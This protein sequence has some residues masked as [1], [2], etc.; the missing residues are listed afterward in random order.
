MTKVQALKKLMEDNEGLASWSLIYNELEKYYPNIKKSKEW[1][2]GIRGVLYR[3]IGKTFKKLDNGLFAILEFKENK[4]L[5]NAKT[6]E[7]TMEIKIRIGQNFFRKVL[8]KN[9]IFCPFTNIKFTDLLIASHIKPWNKSDD[10]ERLDVYNGFIF[11]PTYDKLFDRGYIS[12]RDNKSLL[13]SKSLDKD[14]RQKLHLRDDDVISNLQIT[15]RNK[16]LEYHRDEV[17]DKFNY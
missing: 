11:T 2:A 13:V 14:V 5:E 10:F 12:F 17:Y 6:T 8:L 16:Y 15:N 1:K 4:Y 3:D 9:L 7:K